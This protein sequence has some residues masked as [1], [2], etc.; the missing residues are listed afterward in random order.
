MASCFRGRMELLEELSDREEEERSDG[1]RGRGRAKHPT[2]KTTQH[3]HTW[4]E[5]AFSAAPEPTR[6]GRGGD[7][8]REKKELTANQQPV[9]HRHNL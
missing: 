5:A 7:E 3:K 1:E 6:G 4:G 8:E 9:Q 2:S